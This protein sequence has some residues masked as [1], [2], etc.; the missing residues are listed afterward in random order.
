M[1][2]AAMFFLNRNNELNFEVEEEAVEVS[3]SSQ[4][5]WSSLTGFTRLDL[6]GGYHVILHPGATARIEVDATEEAKQHLRGYLSGEELHVEMEDR[7]FKRF[8]DQITLHIYADE[9]TAIDA[10]GAV[11]VSHESVL[12]T[13]SLDIDVSGAGKIN[14]EVEVDRLDAE[15]SGAGQYLMAGRARE[16]HFKTSG[17]GEV[18]AFDLVCEAVEVRI[19]GAGSAQVHAT[20]SLKTKISGAG[21]VVYDGNPSEIDQRTSGAGSVRK[22]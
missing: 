9:L 3:A 15:I 5:D 13:E 11:S 17:A 1:V 18:R 2:A 21:S 10:S 6:K 7:W 22:R 14:L 4:T 19:S 8:D 12:K 16:A 20:Q